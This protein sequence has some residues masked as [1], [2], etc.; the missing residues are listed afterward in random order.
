MCT[1]FP[2][3]LF[4]SLSGPAPAN[5]HIHPFSQNSIHILCLPILPLRNLSLA[6]F[7]SV[8]CTR[9]HLFDASSLFR[10]LL[11][12]SRTCTHSH[13]LY[14]LIRWAIPYYLYI[15]PLTL[16]SLLPLPRP[17]DL[18]PHLHS[19]R[20][21][22]TLH[23]P[24]L[25]P[26]DPSHSHIR[27][28]R[29]HSRANLD[30]TYSRT[31]SATPPPPA[32]LIRR[33]IQRAPPTLAM[34]IQIHSPTP[35]LSARPTSPSSHPNP[36]H[37]RSSSRPRSRPTSPL[38]PPAHLP[39]QRPPM[40]RPSSRSERLL[41]DTLRKHEER[42]R[43][44]NLSALP[45]PS[46]FGASQ[47]AHG[48]SSPRRHVRRNT[49]SSTGT[50]DASLEGSD[51]FRPEA[52]GISQDEEQDA[53]EGGWLWRTRSATSASSSSSGPQNPQNTNTQLVR[54]P[55]KSRQR[56][57]AGSSRNRS[58]TDPT[59][60]R[61][62]E[63]QFSYGTTTT[64]ASPP[65]PSRAQLPR[66]PKSVPNVSRSSRTS[67]ENH[68][69]TGTQDCGCAAGMTP[70]DVVLKS[71]LESVLRS[72]KEQERRDVER[73]RERERR[74][75]QSQSASGS[76]SGSGSG[77]SMASSR[78][79]SGEGEWFFGS[80]GDV[81]FSFLL[82]SSLNK[83]GQDCTDFNFCF[84]S[85]FLCI[86]YRSRHIR[87]LPFRNQLLPVIPTANNHSP[88]V[89]L[90]SHEHLPPPHMPKDISISIIIITTTTTT[91]KRPRIR[92]R[93]PITSSTLVLPALSLHRP[94]LRSMRA[95]RLN[96]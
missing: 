90:Q 35:I 22:I 11:L 70:H 66:S 34:S 42:D 96:I 21:P 47:P 63:Q 83:S 61:N 19:F 85:L 78:N 15:F 46:I 33:G 64:P 44:A 10:R 12:R 40:P 57:Q 49:N 27:T 52:L 76:G 16:P 24:L 29:C 36:H 30:I 62:Q 4:I 26:S 48:F 92:E 56:Q 94:H 71:R 1:N 7:G 5:F 80:N 51:Y 89:F 13:I 72:A 74:K 91:P 67:L 77:N 68:T 17:F 87:H 88:S 84:F 25:L 95:P 20:A 75:S 32:F 39:L 55:S 28:L 58:H 81:S 41:R 53:D 18:C 43:L 60:G 50:D 69:T 6:P 37:H 86:F 93:A 38:S 3:S 73:E 31:P 45:S 8:V 59:G 65:I 2:F 82:C 54:V 14:Q 23:C 79:M 9:P